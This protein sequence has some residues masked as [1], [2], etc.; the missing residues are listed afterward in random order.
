MKYLYSDNETKQIITVSTLELL[1]TK[2]IDNISILS[3]TKKSTVS[4]SSFY[5]YYDS[6]NDVLLEAV[7]T[8][9]NMTK[10]KVQSSFENSC[11]PHK[12][13]CS[14][15]SII[16]DYG[17]FFR[18]VFSQTNKGLFSELDSFIQSVFYDI[19][20]QIRAHTPRLVFETSIN[21]NELLRSYRQVGTMEII[22][23]WVLADFAVPKEEVAQLILTM[24]DYY[25][26]ER[27]IYT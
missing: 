6:V 7:D 27:N 16:E 9:K 12:K 15:L 22:K 3:I 14:F 21:T 8:I 13:I 11:S 18:V 17:L 25:D 5:Y 19:I 23:K 24:N 1:L 20:L 26:N 4:R 2:N 10:S